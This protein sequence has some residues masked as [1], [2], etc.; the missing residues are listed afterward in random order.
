MKALIVPALLIVVC[1]NIYGQSTPVIMPAGKQ[2][3]VSAWKTLWWGKHYRKEW[4]TPVQFPVL[5]ISTI[6]GGLEPIKVGGGRQTKTLRLISANG[7]EY[8]LRTLDKSLDVLVPDE[9][10]GTFINDLVNDQI[11]TAHPYGP[12]AVAQMAGSISIIH[13]N[14]KIYYV[15][16]DPGLGDFRTVFANKLCLLEERPSGKGWKHSDLFGNAEDVVNT[17]E[18]LNQVF[19][20]TKNS[21]DGQTYLR[22]RLFDMLIN[23]W[24]RHEDQWVWAMKKMNKEHLFVP[25]G[26][27]RD[28]AFSKTDGIALYFLSRRL[29][30]RPL[31]NMDRRV[32]DIRGANFSARN[33]DQQ[34]L[35][36]LTKEDWK[37][38]INFIR[39]NLTDSA[40]ENAVQT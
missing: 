10:K 1:I 39:S 17:E 36:M 12:I 26:R 40:I 29:A 14:P 31:Q 33:L 7:R 5:R 34:F 6:D 25:I 22:A 32:K 20:S 23:D 13:M 16:D 30:L 15:P 18:M 4:A 27:D 8:V 35:T 21:V 2:Y 19:A 3:S 28:Q 24:D 9:L 38:S 37:R 11:S